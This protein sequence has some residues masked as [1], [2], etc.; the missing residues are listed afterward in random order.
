MPNLRSYGACYYTYLWSK[1][2]ANLVWQT[3]FAEEPLS[4]E[5][6]KCAAFYFGSCVLNFDSPFG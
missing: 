2:I 4:R 5:T 3:R 6:G 1:A